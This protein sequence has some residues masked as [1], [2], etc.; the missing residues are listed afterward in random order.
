MPVDA[1]DAFTLILEPVARCNLRCLYCYSDG[2][3]TDVMSRWTLRTA[4]EKTARYAEQQGFR[5]VH[6]LWH[7]GEPLLAGLGFFKTAVQILAGLS[8]D[9]R[10]RHFLQTNGLLLDSDY[11]AFFRDHRFQ[12]GISLDGPQVLHDSLRLGADGQGSHAAV[13]EKVH[14]LEE[15]GLS[16]GFNAVVTRLSLGQE[17]AVYR[18]FQSLGYGFRVNPMIPGR[19]PVASAP[20]LLQPGEYGSFLCR[21]FDVWSGT[22]RRR[23]RVSP[24]DLYLEAVIGEVPY[25]CQQRETCAGSC[26]GVKPSGDTVLCSRVETPTLGNIHDREIRELLASSFCDDL[27]RRAGTL[28]AC[29]PCRHWSICHGGCPLNALVFAHDH[30]ARD[31]FC[32]DYQ[33]IFARMHRALA[34]LPGKPSARPEP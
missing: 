9:L 8:P 7:G 14:F 34:G 27:R 12:I 10:F 6:I 20:F 23:V 4:L 18:Y 13:L 16:I 5:E 21:L 2:A 31:P 11:C 26:L 17:K 15:Q 32:K 19:N 28:A 22:E 3:G 30:L 29:H 24:L 1:P 33:L 25:E